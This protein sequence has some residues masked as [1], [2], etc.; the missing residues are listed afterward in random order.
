MVEPAFDVVCVGE[1]MVELAD[2]G[3]GRG[4]GQGGDALN[5]ALHLARSGWRTGFLTALGND[6]FSQDLRTGWVAEGLDV[7][8]VLAHPTRAVGLYAIRTDGDGERSFHYWRDASAA[9]DMFALPGMA[10]AVA[11][12]EAA[13]VLV[14]SLISLAILPVEGRRALLD[15]AARVRAR[16]GLVAF[17]GNYRPRLWPSAGEAASWRDAAIA[18]ADIGFPTLQDEDD[19]SPTNLEACASHWQRLGCQEVIVKLGARGCR[20]P[21][22]TIVPPPQVVRPVDTS[23]AGDAFNAGYLAARL[24]GLAPRD[25]GL[26]GHRLAAAVVQ[27]A[28]AIPQLDRAAYA[29]LAPATRA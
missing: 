7:S 1:A 29:P 17:D 5:T 28:G 9:R 15:L 26:A 8:L 12:A 18:R 2:A 24:Q 13:R 19:I 21:D 20:L 22:G 10:A 25:C 16:G 23:G 11:L 4:F 3:A 14:F 6:P 27:Q